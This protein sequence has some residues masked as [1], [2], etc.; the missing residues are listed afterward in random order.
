MPLTPSNAVQIGAPAAPFTL[1]DAQGT[2]WT[3]DDFGDAK[4]LLVAFLSNR[5]P[6]VVH[7]RPALAAFAAAYGPRGLAVIGINANDAAAHPE[8][9]AERVRLEAETHGYPFPYVRD[10]SQAVALAYD[11]ACTP[12]LFL[13]GPDRRL[14]YHGQFDGSRPKNDVP[15]TGA[16]L[17]DAVD[18]LLAGLPAPAAQQGSI[19]CNIKW[20]E[21]NEALV[22]RRQAA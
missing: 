4:A 5:C 19:G 15:V 18:R 9:S 6:Y 22:R 10:E 3:L 21:G 2:S 1:K 14:Y 17:R 16:D 20:R 7:I 13:F 12:D 11:A 8:E